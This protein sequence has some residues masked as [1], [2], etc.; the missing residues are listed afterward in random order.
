MTARIVLVS[1]EVALEW[2]KRNDA[3]RLFTRGNARALAAEMER[4]YWQEN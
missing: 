3:N 4:G 2:L 1:P